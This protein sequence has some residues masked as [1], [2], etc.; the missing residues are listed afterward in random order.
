MGNRGPGFLAVVL[1]GSFP[2]PPLLSSV[3]STDDTQEDGERET[4]IADGTGGEEGWGKE[5]KLFGETCFLLCFRT[6]VLF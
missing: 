4:T 2:L 3:S 6:N 1:F 5:P